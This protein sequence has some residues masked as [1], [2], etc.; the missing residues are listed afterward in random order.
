MPA[1]INSYQDLNVWQKSMEL[2]RVVYGLVKFLPREELYALSDQMRRAV[3]SIPSNIAEGYYRN[4]TRDYIRFL[5]MAKGS[6]GEIE[7]QLLLCENFGY[8]QNEQIIPAL[9]K[10]DEISK[11]LT[12][13]INN[14]QAKIDKKEIK[15]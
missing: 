3:V 6:L 10:C 8:L 2:A 14:L 7:T 13:L 4:S 15:K 12:V 1:M 11:M 5:S 9:T